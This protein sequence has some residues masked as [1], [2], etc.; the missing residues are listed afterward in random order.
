MDTGQDLED[1]TRPVE[2]DRRDSGLRPRAPRP[3]DALSERAAASTCTMLLTGETGVGKGH[4]A[5]WIHDR[6][7]R[8]RRPFIPVNCGAIPE[9]LI[10]SQLFGHVRGAFSGAT[11]DHPGLVRAA[12]GGTLFLD[13]VGELPAG[14]QAR[15]LRLLQDR[16]VQPVGVAGPVK[17]DVRIIAATNIDLRTAV[18]DGRFR[19]DLLYRLDVVRVH[20]APLR[21]RRDEVR[22]FVEL[23]NGE[24]ASAYGQE[25]LVFTE[26]AWGVL[27]DHAWPGNVRQLRTVLERL[28]VL[29][30]GERIGPDHLAEIGQLEIDATEQETS[31]LDRI[32]DDEL[33]R[34]LRQCGGSI[35]AAAA[36]LGV[37]RSTVYRWL[38]QGADASIVQ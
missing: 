25:P 2:G 11:A 22:R 14:V 18:A 8:A 28:H 5:E 23:F 27:V 30:P 20:V 10:D 17:V 19:E 35:T 15:L 32:R 29:A 34:V 33:Q 31:P 9:S 13:E 36:R 7:P 4:F 1:V 3:Y 16:E 26:D 6:S 24:F 21:R 12:D 38:R 37:H